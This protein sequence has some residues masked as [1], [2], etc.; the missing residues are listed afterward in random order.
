METKFSNEIRLILMEQKAEKM[1]L[2]GY[3]VVRMTFKK[4]SLSLHF[5]RA[6]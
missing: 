2:P 1:L 6:F 5:H 3:L 4:K